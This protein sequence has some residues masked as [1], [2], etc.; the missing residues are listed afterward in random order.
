MFLHS[1]FAGQ[2]FNIKLF[3]LE[4]TFNGDDFCLFL[5]ELI[6]NKVHFLLRVGDGICLW[7]FDLAQGS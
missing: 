2:I 1:H 3:F 5:T 4:L 7:F 6:L